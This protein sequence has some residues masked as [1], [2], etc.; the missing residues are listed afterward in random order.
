MAVLPLTIDGSFIGRRSEGNSRILGGRLAFPGQFPHQI[1]I[2]VN[3]TGEFMHMCGGSII[4][5]RYI[6]TAAHCFLDEFP[7]LYRYR[8]VVGA[9][10]ISGDGEVHT[11]A[12]RIVHRDYD[13]KRIIHDIALAQ[14]EHT[15]VFNERVR[16]IAI[17]RETIESD[18]WAVTSGWGYT[19]VRSNIS[20]HQYKIDPNIND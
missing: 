6:V 19:D 3:M 17:S 1:A 16:P 9:H 15:I 7:E 10:N 13:K 2:R 8:I 12:N 11:I 4:T 18:N 5:D 14:T 20:I